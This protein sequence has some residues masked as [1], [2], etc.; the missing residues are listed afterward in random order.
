[1]QPHQQQLQQQLAMAN[2]TLIPLSPN[3]AKLVFSWDVM[4]YVCVGGR[5]RSAN[6]RQR[7]PKERPNEKST[8]GNRVLLIGRL[9]ELALYRAE[10]LRTHGFRVVAPSTTAE[11][12]EVIR[13]SQFDIAVLTYTLSSEVIEELAEQIRQYRSDCPLIVISDTLRMDRKI[14]P[15]E[16]VLGEEGPAALI[17]ALRRVSRTS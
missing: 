16:T 8:I 11:A 17:A 7:R 1:M 6:S 5:E 13:R 3:T 14:S 15:D 12:L 2:S 10:V 4:P 9:R